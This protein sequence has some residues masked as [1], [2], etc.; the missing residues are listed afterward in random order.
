MIN[1]LIIIQGIYEV[2]ISREYDVSL[3]ILNVIQ[4][5]HK[6]Y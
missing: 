5:E 2:F 1:F 4:K 6:A 3:D